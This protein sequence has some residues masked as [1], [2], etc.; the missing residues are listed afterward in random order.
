[1]VDNCLYGGRMAVDLSAGGFVARGNWNINPGYADAVTRDY[2]LPKHSLCA[3]LM[4][5][6]VASVNFYQRRLPG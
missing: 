4:A 2:R 3:A 5:R 1:M 6:A